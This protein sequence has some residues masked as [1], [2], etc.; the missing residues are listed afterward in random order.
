MEERELSQIPSCRSEQRTVR[1]ESFRSGCGYF[2]MWRRGVP[3][4]GEHVL[5]MRTASAST[6]ESGLTV[7][8]WP[9]GKRKLQGWEPVLVL[10]C[11]RAASKGVS[12]R[13][14]SE[15]QPLSWGMAPRPQLVRHPSLCPGEVG[16][17]CLVGCLFSGRGRGRRVVTVEEGMSWRYC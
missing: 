11:C 10:D 5:A 3:C 6:S 16:V 8:V 13:V 17:E 12:A 9:W 1:C 14:A 4:T 2:D 7:L 15:F